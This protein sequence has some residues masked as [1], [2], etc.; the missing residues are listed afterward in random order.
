MPHLIHGQ[1]LYARREIEALRCNLS[2]MVAG[3]MTETVEHR[4]KLTVLQ[5]WQAKRCDS[6]IFS[7]H[8]KTERERLC[9]SLS[10]IALLWCDSQDRDALTATVSLGAAIF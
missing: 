1:V 4:Q 2:K 7:N 8:P 5:E 9:L 3:D 10:Q 6:P